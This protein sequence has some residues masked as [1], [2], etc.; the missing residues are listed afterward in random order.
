MQY[1]CSCVHCE[2]PLDGADVPQ[3]EV[4]KTAHGTDLGPHS[5][6]CSSNTTPRLRTCLGGWM[7]QVPVVTEGETDIVRKPITV[8]D[9]SSV[10]WSLS[11]SIYWAS[12]SVHEYL[13][14]KPLSETPHFPSDPYR[15]ECN[16]GCYQRRHDIQAM[17]PDYFSHRG[18]IHGVEDRL[19]HRALGHTHQTEVCRA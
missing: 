8:T 5:H 3:M 7:K 2:I 18:R 14:H 6:I 10:L 15:R 9:C 19:H 11:W 17:P 12:S 4:T 1:A 16:S 13:K